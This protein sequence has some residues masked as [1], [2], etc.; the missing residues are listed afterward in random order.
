M[1][2]FILRRFKPFY[3]NKNFN[4]EFGKFLILQ[5]DEFVTDED[6]GPQ[7]FIIVRLV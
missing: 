2:H 6:T 3:L 4:K 5:P 7:V 1:L